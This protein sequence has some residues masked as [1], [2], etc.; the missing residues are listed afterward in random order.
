MGEWYQAVPRSD[1]DGIKTDHWAA[2]R[3]E[4]SPQPFQAR[5]KTSREWCFGEEPIPC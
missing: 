4:K 3:Q 1:R 2:K 5:A